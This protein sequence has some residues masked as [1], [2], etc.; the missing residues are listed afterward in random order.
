MNKIILALILINVFNT[1]VFS[2]VIEIQNCYADSAIYSSLE[3]M[4]LSNGIAKITEIKTSTQEGNDTIIRKSK[5]YRLLKDKTIN[6]KLSQSNFCGFKFYVEAFD[7]LLRAGLDPL[8]DYANNLP[9]RRSVLI[10]GEETPSESEIAN[11]SLKAK[12]RVFR[13]F[14]LIKEKYEVVILSSFYKYRN[15]KQFKNFVSNII[16]LGQYSYPST[17]KDILLSKYE[18]VNKKSVDRKIKLNLNSRN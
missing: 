17:L 10:V 6:S 18:K 12:A 5:A 14:L 16:D 13:T 7:I 15:E 4:V 8:Y 3:M 2:Q 1:N 11:N 9:R